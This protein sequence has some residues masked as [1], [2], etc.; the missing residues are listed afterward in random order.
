MKN[1]GKIFARDVKAIFT[2]YAALITILALC[3]LPS[4]YAWFNIKASWD[5]Y[6]SESTSGI[7]VA[8]VNLD[9]GADMKGE[10]VNVGDRIVE[11]LKNN[12]QLGWLFLSEIEAKQALE[13]EQIYASITITRD[14]SKSLTSIVSENIQKGRI[15]YTVNEKMNAIAPKLTDKG[16]TNLQNMI[17]QT[18]VETVSNTVFDIA[19]EIGVNLNEQLPKLTEAYDKLLEI[20]GKFGEVNT[21][22]DDASDS[23]TRVGSILKDVRNMI[24][25][26][27]NTLNRISGI[28]SNATDVLN[29]SQTAVDQFTP[30]IKND[31][32]L[33]QTVAQEITAALEGL[34]SLANE[35]KDQVPV[36]I[37]SLQ[38]K[39]N[40]YIE[41]TNSMIGLLTQLN[42][43]SEDYDLDTQIAQLQEVSGVLNKMSALLTQASGQLNDTGAIA[44][45]TMNQLIA[46]ANG[47]QG[48]L[49]QVTNQLEST[50]LPK[51]QA[52]L[53]ESMGTVQNVKGIL[54]QVQQKIPE[55]T[56]T[57]N[58]ADSSV[59]DGEK[60]IAYLE[61]N[62]PVIEAKVNDIITR[63]QEANTEEGLRE[64]IDLL[65]RNMAD[66]SEF[67]T[68]PVEIQEEVL[69][70]MGNYGTS[71]TPFY[72]VLSLWVGLL[73]LSS[74][75]TVEVDGEYK[76]Y[77]VYFGKILTYGV[78][79]LV[80]SLIVSLGDLYLLGIYCKN[81]G[82][83]ILGSL[84]T[85]VT[86]TAIVYSLVSV[87]GN[88][89][90]VISIVLLVLQVAGSGGT[91]PIQMTP[92]FFQ[93]LNPFLPFTYGISFARQCIGGVV[94]EVLFKDSWILLAFIVGFVVVAVLVKKPVNHVVEIFN[95]KFHESGLGE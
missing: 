11:E 86:F 6:G 60:V 3:I 58:Q 13:R 20:Q 7:K 89:G 68:N 43:M 25:E 28:A 42:G 63:I 37:A 65:T 40:S 12:Q 34:Q 17:S 8:V 93:I 85:A 71:M 48:T 44:D 87:F 72:T 33:M 50:T 52:I 15:I 38:T 78:I 21:M 66:R 10:A 90:K 81:P 91:F 76:S 4:L 23:V 5:P 84:F 2:N 67:L 30:T 24:P 53:N 35:N 62:L 75:L 36:V 55:V 9:E 51:V 26:V 69:F 29:Q 1:I 39:L 64:L 59:A 47:I 70:P 56:T 95:K 77:E 83:F 31:L 88:V 73:L 82:L 80:Q 45:E 54:T 14:F 22:V 16:V 19:N 79:A 27:T 57:L 18:V 46:Y 94:R 61:E 32:A 49:A 74:M 41:M 92:R